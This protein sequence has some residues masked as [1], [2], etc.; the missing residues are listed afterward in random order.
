MIFPTAPAIELVRSEDAPLDSADTVFLCLPHAAAAATAVRALDA[1]LR[2]ID[3]SADFRLKDV[4][5]VQRM[6]RGVA[7]P[8]PKLLNEAVYGLTEIARDQLPS[9][10]LRRLSRLLSDKCATCGQTRAG[11]GAGNRNDHRRFEVGRFRCGTRTQAA[12]AFCRG[13]QQFFAIQYRPKT[14]P[15]PRNRTGH[16]LVRS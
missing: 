6:V 13:E 2:V 16:A 5:D 14:S 12:H 15:S 10:R 9:A 3:L 8:A 4:G 1:G 7:H 11:S